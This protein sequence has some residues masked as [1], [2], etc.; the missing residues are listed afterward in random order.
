MDI[1]GVKEISLRRFWN[2]VNKNSGVWMD[3]MTN[4][5]WEWTG[6]KDN[7]GYG[8]LTVDSKHIKA[9][10][11]AYML[12]VGPIPVGFDLDH[13]CCNTTCVNPSH[14]E[15]VTTTENILRGRLVATHCIH[16]HEYT[17]KDWGWNGHR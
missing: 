16:G 6:A 2:K 4:Q 5:C 1:D 7:Q 15:P 17:D 9:A 3:G 11:F 14:L 12:C 8:K 13:L 10:S